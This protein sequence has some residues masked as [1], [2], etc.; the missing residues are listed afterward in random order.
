MLMNFIKTVSL[1]IFFVNG[2]L[3]YSQESN[4]TL[5]ALTDRSYE[6]NASALITL[7]SGFYSITNDYKL[8][9][10]HTQKIKILKEEGLAYANFQIPFS[11]DDS[12]VSFT[13]QILNSKN[14]T[15]TDGISYQATPQI[16]TSI[17]GNLTAS[18]KLSNVK[19]GD[20]LQFRYTLM[21]S[22]LENINTW[23]FQND[24]PVSK[25]IIT[26]KIPSFIFY[27]KFLEGQRK[28]NDISRQITKEELNDKSY[29]FQ[30]EM[31]EMNNIPAYI[32]EV[33]IPG[34]EYFISKLSFY[35]S[36]FTL[37]NQSTKYL[38][39]ASYEELAANWAADKYFNQVN[40]SG[41][42]LE[43]KIAQIYHKQFSDQKNISS[44]YYFMRNNFT[45]N[46]TLYDD[47]L[48]DTYKRRSGNE[49]QINM[50]LAK[51]LNQA[52]FDSYMIALSTIENRP[53][54]PIYPYFSLFNKFVVM[55]K[56]YNQ[57][58]FLDATDPHLL[59]NMLAPNSI[60]N[61]GLYI[62][63]VNNGMIPVDYLFDDREEVNIQIEVLKKDS[64]LIN[65]RN[66]RNGYS[67]Y[68]FD[69]RYL[70]NY[71]SYNDF[72]IETIFNQP[73]WNIIS[74]NVTDNFTE[75]KSVIEEL[76]FGKKQTVNT[77]SIISIPVSIN[78]DFALNPYPRTDRQN[79]IT[80]YTP[81]FRK[82]TYTLTIPKD[83]TLAKLPQSHLAA[84]PDEGGNFSFSVSQNG[85]QVEIAYLLQV[86]KV[87]FLSNEYE[88]LSAFF[89]HV[90]T[91]FQQNIELT[92]D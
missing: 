58:Y 31:F 19:V 4:D 40:R 15:L 20:V 47:D 41:K 11:K 35:L 30:L 17:D 10:D 72:L 61:S 59:F 51:I 14:K 32:K 13:A 73:E 7:D 46:N 70:E 43:E 60:N 75:N 25:S 44:L 8:V 77:E 23:Y 78:N 39:P 2:S 18:I 22:T 36:E 74:H 80:L 64:L 92:K 62:S 9:F 26:L 37:P 82:G 54:Y 49:Q 90:S 57:T 6:K 16:T 56:T 84:L 55:V 79:P 81:I 53:S 83:Y 12:L 28:L 1:L 88:Q 91:T 29:N 3:A 67:V 89:D 71:K 33:D 63:K 87:I 50:L 5:E 69:T 38:L 24:I 21:L 68:S 42:Y 34:N 76:Q 85:Q 27:Y 52:G 66:I 48:F 86:N 45:V 65:Y